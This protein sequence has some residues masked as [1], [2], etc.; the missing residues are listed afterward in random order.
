MTSTPL[1]QRFDS[2]VVRVFERNVRH[3][4]TGALDTVGFELRNSVNGTVFGNSVVADH[5][6]GEDEDL[7]QVGWVGH[8]VGV[9][10][11]CEF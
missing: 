4:N 8:G 11:E 9:W 3:D 10:H 1:V 6:G 5:G 2:L 7:A